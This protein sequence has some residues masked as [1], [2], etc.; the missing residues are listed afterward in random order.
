MSICK[1]DFREQ[2]S[3]K[4]NVRYNITII[5][6][7]ENKSTAATSTCSRA[8]INIIISIFSWSKLMKQ[9]FVEFLCRMTKIQFLLALIQIKIIFIFIKISREGM[10]IGQLVVNEMYSC[11]C[12][13]V[14]PVL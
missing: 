9:C 4:D 13:G 8:I 5:P 2:L 3:S 12:L 11:I 6:T 7:C 1:P 14:F 10:C